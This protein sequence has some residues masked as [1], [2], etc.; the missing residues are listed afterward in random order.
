VVEQKCK[1]GAIVVVG[2]ETVTVPG[3][4]FRALHFRDED[5]E[6]WMS[7]DLGF[8]LVR[9]VSKKNGTMELTGHGS[10]AT[11]SITET[12]QVMH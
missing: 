7:A 4:S 3:G 12:P 8:P 9:F 11:S 1:E 2:W 6:G 5:D 10:D